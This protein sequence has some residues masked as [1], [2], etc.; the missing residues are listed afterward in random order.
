VSDF[1]GT[2]VKI[3]TAI[4]VVAIVAALLSKKSQTTSV[5]SSAGSFFDWLVKT[6]VSP[7]TGGSGTTGISTLSGLGSLSLPSQNVGSNPFGFTI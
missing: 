2:V 6:I 3:L 4:V 1:I 7:I 5:I